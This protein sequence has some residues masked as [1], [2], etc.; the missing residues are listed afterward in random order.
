MLRAPSLHDVTVDGATVVWGTDQR[1]VARLTVS[2][3]ADL[4]QAVVA[5]ATTREYGSMETRLGTAL[6]QH[7]VRM[8]G[9]QPGTEYFYR[10]SVDGADVSAI[11]SFRTAPRTGPF[12]FLVFGDSGTG[13]NDQRNVAAQMRAERD[14]ALAIHVGDV[15]YPTPTF[16]RY[17]D[18]HFGVYADLMAKI[19]FY[20]C[21][22]NHDVL[23]DHGAAY[24]ALHTLP[25][26]EGVP[27]AMRG[28]YYSFD[29]GDVHFVA[30]DTNEILHEANLAPM[31]EW[32]DRDLT[33]TRKAWKI[34]FW[35]HAPYDSLRGE[36]REQTAVRER[37]APLMDKHGVH[38]VL[39]G[40]HHC[41]QRTHPLIGGKRV[42]AGRGTV[43][44]TSGGGGAGLYP[45]PPND[46]NAAG[47][48][49]HHH[50][51]VD[52]TRGQLRV[53]AVRH[54]GQE[55]DAAVIAPLPALAENG[56]V[57]GA[58][59]EAGVAAGGVMSVFGRNLAF[60]TLGFS[61]LPLPTELAGVRVFAGERALPLLFVSPGQINALLPLD[62]TGDTRVRV[63]TPNGAAEM[64]V[65][66]LETAPAIFRYNGHAAITRS[67]GSQVTPSNPVFPGETLTAYLTGLG[68]VHQPVQIGAAAPFS[69]AAEAMA[70]VSVVL[71]GSP[72]T[73]SFAGLSPGSAGLYQVNFRAPYELGSGT[74][75]LR[76]RA[77]G[78]Q[79]SPV[80][81]P[82]S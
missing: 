58:T 7:E 52:V 53:R 2:R 19:P 34:A 73:P 81:L 49:D 24:L 37:L 12:R 51:T 23:D 6:F 70:R 16:Q 10:A 40:H 72:I 60:E 77:G 56:I 61:T 22:G 64:S 14:L 75:G 65:N 28:H 39:V 68:R 69:P 50:C 20:P 26:D 44:V 63:V 66:V 15:V 43:Y 38:L 32:A 78:G 47:V 76:I 5:T 17:L 71:D 67:D 82:I 62:R 4:Q 18:Y 54:N 27:Q 80:P 59:F 3:R 13:L 31:I 41:Y 35:H 21:L 25:P 74:F 30:L 8:T 55:M 46:F 1:G 9:L 79:S 57:N 29:W 48:S 45:I 11:W 42:E 36:H 33:M